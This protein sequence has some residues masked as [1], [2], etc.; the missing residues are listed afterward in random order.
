MTLWARKTLS[1]LIP[2]ESTDRRTNLIEGRT[3]DTK[4]ETE[5]DTDKEKNPWIVEL[6]TDD[7]LGA[8]Q[9]LMMAT[10]ADTKDAKT[11]LKKLTPFHGD[12][13]LIKKFIQECDLYIL[14]NLKDFPTNDSK[15]I[16][17]LSYVYGWWRSQE[18]EAILHRQWSDD[19]CWILHLA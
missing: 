11:H 18:I 16:F 15:V 7:L 10:A 6:I 2:N 8:L 3:F 1:S 4:T 12:R 19:H 14:R 5:L 17:I 13:K 9:T